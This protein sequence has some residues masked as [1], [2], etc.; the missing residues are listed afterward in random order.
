[1]VEVKKVEKRKKLFEQVKDGI[2]QIIA[3]R[4]LKPNDPIPSE[5]QLAEK[6]NVSRMTSKV[7]IQSLVD[8]GILYRFPRKGTFV[9]DID[10][11]SISQISPYKGK[12]IQFNAKK[13]LIAL[14]LPIFDDFTG[15]IIHSVERACNERGYH[16]I[17]KMSDDLMME[18]QHLSNMSETSEV[19]GIILFP[20]GRKVCGEQL[21][22]L[23][24]SKYPIVILDR[25]FKEIDFDCVLHDH[26]LSAYKITKY[27]IDHGHRKIGFLTNQID[28]A[29][30]REERYQGYIEAL[31]ESQ[32]TILTKLIFNVKE[33]PGPLERINISEDPVIEDIKDYLK[34][35]SDVTAVV[36]TEDF[37]AIKLAYAA[38]KLGIQVP[39][40]LSISGFTDNKV[41]D[42]F[43]LSITTV[44]QP[45]ELFGESA[46][47]LL[48]ER[49][50]NPDKPLET[51]KLETV[52][53]ENKSVLTI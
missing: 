33:I 34:A 51:I 12:G 11:N 10:I 4:D 31:V 25:S 37:L 42:Y 30:S 49:V 39:Q 19:L 53:L 48:L 1:M 22:K 21:M 23:R 27:L 43:P 28:M 47:G 24:L 18:D 41:L 40:D 45:T 3:E 20:R 7:A 26:Y 52:I 16:L 38:G 36:C 46:L 14:I 35:N 50:D 8:E 17:V 13:K 15:N 9:G 44:K 32:V 5:G 6:F 29:T 2:L